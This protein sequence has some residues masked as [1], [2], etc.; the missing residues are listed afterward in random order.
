MTALHNFNTDME[1]SEAKSQVL[2]QD[3]VSDVEDVTN[4]EHKMNFVQAIKLYPKAVAW[5]VMMST[6]LI[7]DGYDLKVEDARKSKRGL[8]TVDSSSSALS[9]RNLRLGRHMAA[10]CRTKHTKSRLPGSLD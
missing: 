7:M 8:L 9:L 2:R 4:R 3:L 6:A 10:V 5:S 1:K